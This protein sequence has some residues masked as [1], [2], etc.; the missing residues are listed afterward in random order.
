MLIRNLLKKLDIDTNVMDG[1]SEII[2]A[3]ATGTLSGLASHFGARSIDAFL[4]K[5][6]PLGLSF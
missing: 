4:K 5:T 1:F 2:I 3:V 6:C